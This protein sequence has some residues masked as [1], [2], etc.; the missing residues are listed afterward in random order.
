MENRVN[1]I[2]GIVPAECWKYCPGIENPADIPSRGI[3][4]TE[5]TNCRLWRYGP[6]W[7]VERNPVLEG[8]GNAMPD[9]C[10]KEIKS[11]RCY[12]MHASQIML[13]LD[14]IICCKNF[15][16]LR[17]LLRV[18]SYV[19]KF[20][21][22]CKSRARASEI[23]ATELTAKDVAKAEII[24][25]KELQK[26][27]L[28][29]KDFP[30]WKR[31]FNLF[32]EGEVWRC[33]GRLGNSEAPYN[34]KHPIL[35][36]K[37]H[38]LAVLI[39]Q[40]AHERV[41]HNGVKETLTELRSKYWIIKGRQFVRRV[42]HKCIICRKL[43]GPP[44]ALPPPPPL[45]DF[46]VTEQPPFMYT[47]VDFAGPLY[48]KTQGL[49]TS[50]KVWICLFTCCVIRAVHLDIVPDLTTD[51][52]I[53]CFKRFTARRGISHKM[54]SDNGKTFK[55]AAKGISAVLNSSVVQGYSANTRV[56]WSFNL[57]KAP[58]WGGLFERLI[59]STK[60]C[61][62]KTIGQARITYDE[63]VTVVTEVEMILNSRPLSYVST[64]DLEEPLTPSHLLMG[65]RV[66]SLPDPVHVHPEDDDWHY[67]SKESLS[68]R[69]RHLS[70]TMQHFWK[71]WRGEYLLQLR[72]CHRQGVKGNSQ[73]LKQGDIVLVHNEAHP[74]GLWKIA[75]IERLL[76]GADG[77]V[78]GAEIRV[79]S[80]SSNKILRRPLNRLYPLE[81][82]CAVSVDP[83]D[84]PQ[85][86]NKE[87]QPSRGVEPQG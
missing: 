73:S 20:V 67:V 27:L 14:K 51:S 49:I 38:H 36:I 10:L 29:H 81:I 72:E 65:R 74:R 86:T 42:I 63:L 61:L 12:V 30:T 54:I 24:W 11:T 26:E 31:Q 43:E 79:S 84:G 7:L 18:T 83:D 2:R 37:S 76:E 80:K 9:E 19:L 23:V 40:D 48:I 35:L 77:Q 17:R 78:R 70:M 34:A 87:A 13:S 52:F 39:V 4:P 47:G 46:R 55:A 50:K 16:C 59:K 82:D 71:R 25:V 22:Q 8:E 41:M 53:R 3:M 69:A 85:K 66:L 44:Y 28:K 57:E 6:T 64:E 33:G 68:N 5:L 21:E 45:P 62:K 56:Q 75:K 32:L 60:R 58:W 15:G 1:E